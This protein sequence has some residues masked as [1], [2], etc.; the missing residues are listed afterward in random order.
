[1]PIKE[2]LAWNHINLTLTQQKS[3]PKSQQAA[4]NPKVTVP[5]PL[6]LQSL[7]P[8]WQQGKQKKPKKMHK[9]ES[10][11]RRKTQNTQGKR[12]SYLR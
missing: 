11:P 10:N 6:W 1:M 7:T 9:W 3:N 5:N 12:T 2:N 4:P 8:L